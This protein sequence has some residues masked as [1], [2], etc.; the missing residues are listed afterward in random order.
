V[1]EHP[2][3]LPPLVVLESFDGDSVNAYKEL[4]FYYFSED[5]IG[6]PAPCSLEGKPII[7]RYQKPEEGKHAGFWHCFTEGPIERDRTPELRRSE[8]IR[9]IRPVIEASGTDRV[10]CWETTRGGKTRRLIGLPDFSYVVILEERDDA[11]ILIT[12]YAVN[13]ERKAETLRREYEEYMRQ[14]KHDAAPE[15]G[16]SAPSTPR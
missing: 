4:I 16:V 12:A 13:Y 15:D 6:K 2:S 1:S 11:F 5:L 8:R 3:W 14:K 7:V 9:W 10:L